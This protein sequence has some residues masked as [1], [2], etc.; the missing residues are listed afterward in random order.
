MPSVTGTLSEVAGAV[1]SVL[2]LTRHSRIRA[3]MHETVE[4]FTLM[5][6]HEELA[7]A[8]DD[9]RAVIE[10]QAKKLL[11]VAQPVSRRKWAFGPAVLALIVAAIVAVPGYVCYRLAGTP[12]WSI[13]L[14]VVDGAA[15]A[16]FVAVAL[17]LLLEREDVST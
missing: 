6:P 2:G 4:L 11:S 9:L 16:L 8:R 12:W 14:L 13:V 3:Q 15:V 7:A 1:Q 10:D 5:Q 17:A